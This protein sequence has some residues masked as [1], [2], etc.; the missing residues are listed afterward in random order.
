MKVQD[1]A[2]GKSE[3]ER[4]EKEER[5]VRERDRGRSERISWSC[6]SLSRAQPSQSWA[7]L[8]HW[9]S[10]V[11]LRPNKTKTKSSRRNRIDGI[12]IVFLSARTGIF[13]ILFLCLSSTRLQRNLGIGFFPWDVFFGENENE[14]TKDVTSRDSASLLLFSQT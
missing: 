5:G 2:G 4:G 9:P 14:D 8:I 6:D 3:W 1:Q 11:E 10:L 12:G 7:E 13:R